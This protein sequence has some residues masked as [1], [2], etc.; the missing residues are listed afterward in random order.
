MFN[1]FKKNTR[2]KDFK[3]VRHFLMSHMKQIDGA[4]ERIPQD[5]FDV[6]MF[7]LH[8]MIQLYDS[9]GVLSDKNQFRGCL[10]LARSLLESSI[11][12]QYIYKEDTERRAK[13]FKCKSYEEL[14][15]RGKTITS[16][17][18]EYKVFMKRLETEL[19][20]YVPD[21]KTIREK[22]KELNMDSTYENAYKR[23][24]GFVHVGYR[25]FRDFDDEGPYN[26]F[27]KRLVFSDTVLFML[28]S[29]ESVCTRYD[30]DGGVMVIDD[31]GY[32]GTIFYATNPKKTEG[33]R[34]GESL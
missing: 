18:E 25:P 8:D 13:D 17:L 22:A 23:L 33:E 16:D 30:L 28:K 19:Q 20:D 24:S 7:F 12:F 34:A 10:P 32:I 6:T 15:K 29:L 5:I 27:L 21:K 3:E 9:I 31:P 14:R 4:K 2:Q 26:S 11:N 1:F